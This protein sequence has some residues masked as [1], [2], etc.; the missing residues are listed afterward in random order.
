VLATETFA[1]GTLIDQTGNA[2][3][4]YQ[5]VLGKSGHFDGRPSGLVVAKCQFVDAVDDSE[6]VHRLEKHRRL[7][8]FPQITAGSFNNCA[9]VPECLF[10]LFLDT[11][12]HDLSSRGIKRDVPR[13]EQ[14]IPEFDSLGIRANRARG[15]GGKDGG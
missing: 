14:E 13:D 12:G 4:F 3:D 15:V 9:E 10:C 1:D 2:L 6:V 5:H 11:A 8:D 7:H